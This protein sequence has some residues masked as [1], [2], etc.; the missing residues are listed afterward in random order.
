MRG[1]IPLLPQY[2]F[3]AWCSI[4]A[5]GKLHFNS[6]R[7]ANLKGRSTWGNLGIDGINIFKYVLR[8]YGVKVWSK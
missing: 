6:S 3:M 7:M 5:Q 2:T 8:K 4:K 1:D